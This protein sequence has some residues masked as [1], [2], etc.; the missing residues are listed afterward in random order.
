M[1]E[2]QK[3]KLNLIENIIW[4]IDNDYTVNINKRSVRIEE[5]FKSIS[6]N[7]VISKYLIDEWGNMN[8]F[9]DNMIGIT[10][11]KLLSIKNTIIQLYEIPK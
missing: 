9:D 7:K 5:L 4:F 1:D 2:K 10:N 6:R 8:Y 3:M 11:E